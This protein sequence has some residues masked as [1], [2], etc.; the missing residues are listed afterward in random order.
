M[1]GNSKYKSEATNLDI[2]YTDINLYSICK[3]DKGT[4]IKSV[5]LL[6]PS[7]FTPVFA[8]GHLNND[9]VVM[10]YK[11][12]LPN[13]D[14]ETYITTNIDFYCENESYIFIAKFFF[15]TNGS[16]G[17]I[18]LIV[19]QDGGAYSLGSKVLGVSVN[20]EIYGL[21]EQIYDLHEQ[22]KEGSKPI[23]YSCISMIETMGVCG[24]SYTAGMVALENPIRE[25]ENTSLSW[26]KVL[27]RKYGIDVSVY[28]KGGMTAKTYLTDERCL[29]KL[30]SESAKQL[31]TISLGHNDAY[32][33]T[34]VGD[35]ATLTG[36]YAD[37]PDTFI[38]NYAKI[39]EQIKEHAQKAMIIL[40]RQTRPY[41]LL[42]NGAE[43]NEAISALGEHYELP[44][45]DPE[46]D[47]Y[48]SSQTWLDTM[49][50]R[51]PVFPGYA[52]M[53]EAFARQF[54][55]YSVVYWDYFMKYGTN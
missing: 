54:S 41:A 15:N 45:F 1:Y 3:V 2:P 11:A 31:Y 16:T 42:N 50:R 33:E 9:T 48:L 39:I 4:K 6:S 23:T 37:Y 38:G 49:V 47:P 14:G 52:G 28:A 32:L 10:D 22:I 51:H 55:Y 53:A 13:G 46:L 7:G 43:L 8:I 35:I 30:L 44:V 12:N 34:T 18:P 24:D 19:S 26:G 27:G 17:H 25:I 40:L 21:N 20:I 29:P 36:S 5:S